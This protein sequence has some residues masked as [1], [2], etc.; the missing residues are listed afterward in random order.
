MRAPI[1]RLRPATGS[2]PGAV[3]LPASAP[4]LA[5]E[6]AMKMSPDPFPWMA[7]VRGGECPGTATVDYREAVASRPRPAAAV[8]CAPQPA[9]S[10]VERVEC[11]LLL[12]VLPLH[13]VQPAVRCFCPHLIPERSYAIP[14]DHPL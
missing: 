11:M 5:V 4:G 14:L 2:R 10:R 8:A 1:N 6:N 7:P 12:G 13:V 9:A 3:L